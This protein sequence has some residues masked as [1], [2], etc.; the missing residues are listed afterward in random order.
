MVSSSAESRYNTYASIIAPAA[1]GC[2]LGI[3]F[4]RGMERKTSNIISFSLLAAGAVLAV[5]LMSDLVDRAA[6]KLGSDRRGRRRLEGIRN[7]AVPD[8]DVH[9]FF[10]LDEDPEL[11]VR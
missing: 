4:G 11:A 9:D 5:P 10:V 7:G 2:A 1:A 3:L 6:T 8:S